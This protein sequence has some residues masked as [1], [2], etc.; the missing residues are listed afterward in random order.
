MFSACYFLK[1]HLHHFS[2]IKSKKESQNS[3]NQGYSYYFGMMIEGSGSGSPRAGSGSGSIPLTSGSGSGGSGSATLPGTKQYLW[4]CLCGPLS[5]TTRSPRW[6]SPSTTV[7][8]RRSRSHSTWIR[9]QWSVRCETLATRIS[10]FSLAF[11]FRFLSHLAS[12]LAPFPLFF[13]YFC[14]LLASFHFKFHIW[15]F[16]I[17]PKLTKKN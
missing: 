12:F 6:T 10:A 9:P 7:L 16:W 17:P 1:L 5:R 4:R 2:K 8:S 13:A 11:I 14:I 3:R 15:S